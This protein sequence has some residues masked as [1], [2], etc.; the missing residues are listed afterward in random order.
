MSVIYQQMFVVHKNDNKLNTRLVCQHKS[1]LLFMYN[2]GCHPEVLKDKYTNIC[3]VFLPPNTISLLQPLDF[4]II[5][6]IKMHYRTLQL[7]YILSKIEEC[8][9]ASELT[10]SVNILQAI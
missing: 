5:K 3:V 6:N 2:A 1:I 4:G 8:T 10:N 9:S 7:T